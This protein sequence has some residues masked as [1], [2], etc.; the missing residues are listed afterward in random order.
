MWFPHSIT[1]YSL[2]PSDTC[3]ST[4]TR[5]SVGNGV[6][7]GGP[8]S[9][10]PT[11]R[12]E[13]RDVFEVV[14]WGSLDLYTE[15]LNIPVVPDFWLRQDSLPGLS[16]TRLDTSSRR[17]PNPT[18]SGRSPTVLK[19]G[20]TVGPRLLS[21]SYPSEVQDSPDEPLRLCRVVS[22]R[23]LPWPIDSWSLLVDPISTCSDPVLL[24][25][26][27]RCN[28]GFWRCFRG[29]SLCRDEVTVRVLRTS[30]E[31]YHG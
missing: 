27:S 14:W 28:Y 25:S 12:V 6:V 7:G 8:S 23:L 2:N 31:C 11:D 15:K 5:H 24:T 29:R 19:R 18:W 13:V 16:P 10:L 9:S 4:F 21:T 26:L 17:S 1:H 20:P 30:V 22:L 3:F